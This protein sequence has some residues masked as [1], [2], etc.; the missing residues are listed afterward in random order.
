MESVIDRDCCLQ[1]LDC[2]N[3]RGGHHSYV[4]LDDGR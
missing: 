1:H 4:K 2:R 3:N